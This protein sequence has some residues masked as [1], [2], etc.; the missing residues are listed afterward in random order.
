VLALHSPYVRDFGGFDRPWALLAER[1]PDLA[2]NEVAM[3][4]GWEAGGSVGCVR[5]PLR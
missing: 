3:G 2:V 4:G 5:E 1:V